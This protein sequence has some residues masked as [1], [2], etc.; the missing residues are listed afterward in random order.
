V[1]TARAAHVRRPPPA[2]LPAPG[3]S[4]ARLD[5][6]REALAGRGVLAGDDEGK[7]YT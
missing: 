4:G 7:T 3:R 1:P 6:L 2:P 5:P